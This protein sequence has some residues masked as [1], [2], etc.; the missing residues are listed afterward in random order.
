M[1]Y[2]SVKF[3]VIVLE[4]YDKVTAEY[5][6]N[7]PT[8]WQPLE[9]L[10]RLEGGFQINIPDNSHMT[11]VNDRIKQVRWHKMSLRTRIQDI[12]FSEEETILLHK[13]METVFGKH[14]VELVNESS[15][16]FG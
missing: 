9:K 4:S 16:Y 11:D 2:V 7:K 10:N 8:T 5:N 6:K 1:P 12:P 3:K 14:K 13:S 15:T